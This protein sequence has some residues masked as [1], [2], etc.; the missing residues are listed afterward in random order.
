ME[1]ASRLFYR[2]GINEVGVGEIVERA[3]VARM[4]LYNRFG[5]KDGL[6]A[7]CLRLLDLRY[8]EWFVRQVAARTDDPRARIL[9]VFDV[10]GEWFRSSGFRGCAFINASVELSDPAHPGHEP[11][12]AHKRRTRDYLLE[13]ADDAGVAEPRALADS[14]MLLIEG[15][16]VTALVE[17]DLDAAGRGR[18]AAGLLLAGLPTA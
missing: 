16:I 7:D 6:V 5:S 2:R 13:L 4:T 18:R 3:D 9:A 14:L 12:I 11:I 10:L 1:E 17:R 15:A 8:H